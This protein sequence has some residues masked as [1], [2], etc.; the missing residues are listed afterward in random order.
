MFLDKK[1]II[2]FKFSLSKDIDVEN[3]VKCETSS[4][5]DKLEITIN[6]ASRGN[7]QQLWLPFYLNKKQQLW[8]GSL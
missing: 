6:Q 7:Q 3:D 1:D 5:E 4:Q 2:Q 8:L